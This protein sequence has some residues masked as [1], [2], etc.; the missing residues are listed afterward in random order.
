MPGTV[1]LP[2]NNNLTIGTNTQL[3]AYD[4]QGGKQVSETHGRFYNMSY[5]GNLFTTSV[6]A[7]STL[8]IPTTLATLA[9]KFCILNPA[10][11]GVNL[12][13]IRF[14]AFV[15]SATLVANVWGLTKSTSAA[16]ALATLTTGVINNLNVNGGRSAQ[17]IFY[18]AATHTDTPVWYYTLGAIN[19]TTGAGTTLSYNF[20]GSLILPPGNCI[21]LVTSAATQ[22]NSIPQM[23]WAE[24]P[25]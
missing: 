21:D 10:G 18:V 19:A 5:G 16:A 12:E 14:D 6:P 2:I 3:D 24:W 8:T 7:A 20:D 23:I 1:Q 22:A 15:N 4:R 25:I 11:S 17:A 9:S 13:F